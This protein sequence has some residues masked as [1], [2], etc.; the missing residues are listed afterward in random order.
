MNIIEL[1]YIFPMS[2]Y[3]FDHKLNNYYLVHV[4]S[5]LKSSVIISKTSLPNLANIN[6]L[7]PKFSTNIS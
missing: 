6:A 2:S 3:V 4:S 5:H 1:N 7:K